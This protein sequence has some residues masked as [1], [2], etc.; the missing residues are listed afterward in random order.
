MEQHVLI[1]STS[2]DLVSTTTTNQALDEAIEDNIASM[3]Y[4]IWEK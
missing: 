4:I 2:I 1:K 3:S